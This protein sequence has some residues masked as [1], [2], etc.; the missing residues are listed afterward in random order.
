[1]SIPCTPTEDFITELL[2]TFEEDDFTYENEP[3]VLM[4]SAPK[5]RLVETT[6][7][8]TS[9]QQLKSKEQERIT[10]LEH[11]LATLE[12]R[13]AQVISVS[14]QPSSSSSSS[15]SPPSGI[16]SPAPS[17]GDAADKEPKM[18]PVKEILG[19]CNTVVSGNTVASTVTRSPEESLA[20]HNTKNGK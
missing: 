13:F 2:H 10:E 19:F 6:E 16:S 5:R 7:G 1:M 14:T 20:S 4:Q 15:L 9:V 12:K 8:T 11:K 17:V 18:P 3:L